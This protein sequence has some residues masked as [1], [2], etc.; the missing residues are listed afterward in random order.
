L[1]SNVIKKSA[2]G[3][4][5]LS[6]LVLSA[7]HPSQVKHSHTIHQVD[8]IRHGSRTT[9]H[10]L[11]GINYPALW[12]NGET[13]PA[14]YNIPQGQLTYFGMQEAMLLGQ[15]VHHDS[16]SHGNFLPQVYSPA[17][18][19]VRTTGIN[20]TIMSAVSVITGLYPTLTQT[21]DN[22][23]KIKL[24]SVAYQQDKLLLPD[25]TATTAEDSLEQSPMW[26]KRWESPNGHEFYQKLKHINRNFFPKDYALCGETAGNYQTC[27]KAII[28]VADN[29]Q[30][31]QDYCAHSGCSVKK[32]LKLDSA[33]QKKVLDAFAWYSIHSLLPTKDFTGSKTVFKQLSRDTGGRLV[34]VIAAN[35]RAYSMHGSKKSYT[36]FSAH[37]TTV[38]NVL[39]YLLAQSHQDAHSIIDSYPGFVANVSFQLYKDQSDHFKVKVVYYKS[40]QARRSRNG[41]TVVDMPLKQFYETYYDADQMRRMKKDGTVFCQNTQS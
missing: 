10:P 36:L 4:V 38:F 23:H 12:D 18:V 37:D 31:L 8:V 7:C 5:S 17:H 11:K 16:E 19:C 15:A 28:P 13:K 39:A 30:T 2:Y 40:Y 9:L 21:M 41:K 25:Q 24:H 32:I 20:R 1:R 3:L 34:S 22:N 14:Y 6:V 26:K 29:V 35:M 33:M 27:L